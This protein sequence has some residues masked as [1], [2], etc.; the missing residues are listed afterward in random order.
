MKFVE[1]DNLIVA[2]FDDGENFIEELKSLIEHGAPLKVILSGLGMFRNVKL[3]Y[4]EEGKYIEHYIPEPVEVLALSGSLM[5]NAEPS[6]HIHA[7]IGLKSG[8]VKGGHLI[9]AEVWNT[10]EIFF[11][12]G[13]LD[14]RR[15]EKKH[16]DL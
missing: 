13:E 3:G 10:L 11:Q 14:L 15:N 8:E 5:K 1:K 9:S 6:Y 16:I 7:V 12:K 2:R 4:F